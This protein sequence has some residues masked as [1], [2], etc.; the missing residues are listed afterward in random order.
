MLCFGASTPKI[1]I[2]ATQ[3]TE[4]MKPF[5]CILTEH[6]PK[7]EHGKE[8]GKGGSEGARLSTPAG[9]RDCLKAA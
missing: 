6:E 7:H 9:S 5:G 4:K 1:L 3:N 2:F 8:R